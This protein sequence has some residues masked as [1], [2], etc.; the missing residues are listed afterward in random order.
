MAG[1][2]VPERL[3]RLECGS[4]E[5]AEEQSLSQIE[6]AQTRRRGVFGMFY[7][8][9]VVTAAVGIQALVAALFTQSY[10]AYVV[11]LR[12]DFGWSKT[13]LSA[14]Y[15]MLQAESG[16]TGPIQGWLT[17]RYGPRS[18]IRVGLIILSAGFVLLGTMQNL[19]MFFFAVFVLAVGVSLSGWLPLTTAVV[20]WF[21][22]KRATAL[23]LMST[24][25][26]LGGL[27]VPLTVLGLESFGWR[28][29]ALATAVA[30]LVIGLPLV[31]LVRGKPEDYGMEMDGGRPRLEAESADQTLGAVRGGP[32]MG[33]RDYALK[34]A[35]RTRQF[36]LI[37]LGHGSALLIVSAVIVHLV[38]HLRDGLG[39]SLTAAGWFVAMM[40]A[41]QVVG[42]VGGG[43]LGDRFSK[44]WI[45]TVCMFVHA[46]ALLLL[47]SASALWMVMAFAVMHGGAWGVRGPLM[48]AIRADYFGRTAFG[49]IMGVSQPI[50]M[51]GMVSGSIVAG[52][53]ADRTG[54]YEVGFTVLAALAALGSAFF[55]FAP[56]PKRLG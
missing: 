35:L 11:L 22:R 17:E 43:W 45:A 31:Q 8:W 28:T 50:I 53:L 23:G 34:E 12:E 38:S 24:G 3:W 4:P 19:P 41:S 10:G 1:G 15:S 49:T 36:W 2:G 44:R 40:T 18:V 56:A 54:S 51:V 55:I 14:G 47:A 7:G 16:I 29:M 52:V 5:R 26:A 25:V 46:G 39:Y 21:E 32:T 48:A 42:T 20:N 6:Q 27:L 37:S 33:G 9:W 30:T 13:T